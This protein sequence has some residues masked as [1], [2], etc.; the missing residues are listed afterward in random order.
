MKVCIETDHG[1]VRLEAFMVAT[2]KITGFWNITLCRLVN[3]Y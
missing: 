2:L 3:V 1:Y